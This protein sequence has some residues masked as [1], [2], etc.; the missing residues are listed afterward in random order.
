MKIYLI[1]HGDAVHE[2]EAGSD[3]DR[4]LSARGR[5][6]A[7]ILARLLREQRVEPDAILCSPLPRAVQTAELVANGLDYIGQVIATRGL[8]PSAQPRVAAEIL[9]AMGES[10]VVVSH[11]P[12]VSALGAFLLGRPAFPPFRTA[13]C[14]AI[15]GR[16]P[17]WSARPDIDSV[18]AYFVD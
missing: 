8:E 14:F 6:H 18:Q 4:W 11:E 9:L 17:T 3:R 10:V 7:R 16:A 5:E 13:Q 15:E 1:R 12:A 2:D